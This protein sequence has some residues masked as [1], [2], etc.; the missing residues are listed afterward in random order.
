MSDDDQT[1]ARAGRRT[2]PELATPHGESK[3][4]RI[5][6]IES[7][8]WLRDCLAYALMMFLPGASI[9]GVKSADEVAP[10]PAKLLLIG[11]D[12]RSGCEPAQ[13]RETVQTLQRLGDGSPIGAYLHAHNAAVVSLLATLGVAGIVLPDA[14]VEIAVASVRLMAAGGT[15]LPP[16]LTNM[17]EER[18]VDARLAEFSPKEVVPQAIA[19]PNDMPPL[20]R[21]LTARERE[22]LRSLGAGQANKYIA[23][24]LQ[25]SES[26]VKVHLRNIMRK[27]HAT[28]RTQAAVQFSASETES[29]KP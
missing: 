28:N 15:C 1:A 22:V 6:L 27:L 2:R 25:I 4:A 19:R 10:G 17:R 29:T 9:E 16:T 20:Y 8:E 3:A 5:V 23:S 21:S 24:D 26:T 12:P 13:L 7:R 14:S 18:D 11:L